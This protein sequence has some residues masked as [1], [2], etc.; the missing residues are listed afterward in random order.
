MKKVTKKQLAE[1]LQTHG[2]ATERLG[3]IFLGEIMRLVKVKSRKSPEAIALLCLQHFGK[4]VTLG[5]FMSDATG[6]R[7]EEV[8]VLKRA[9]NRDPFTDVVNSLQ[10]R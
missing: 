3:R 9:D 5:K 7:M 6:R 2:Y 8:V 10:P 4:R 1:F